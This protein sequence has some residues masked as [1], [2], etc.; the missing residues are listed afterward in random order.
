[1]DEASVGRAL[2]RLDGRLV[3]QKHPRDGV[4]GGW[5]YKVICCVSDT[6]APVVYTWMDAY[7]SPLPLSSALVDA[8]QSH[9]LGARNK[10]LGEDEFNRRELESRRRDAE[11]ETEAVMDDHRPYMERGRISVAMSGAQRR[12]YWQTGGKV[13]VSGKRLQRG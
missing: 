12:R 2:K 4:A 11:R 1:M 9:M 5:V 6:Y 10:P 8:V 3:L 7:G 13:P